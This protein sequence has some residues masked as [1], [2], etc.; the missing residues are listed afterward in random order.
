M[1]RNQK[2]NHCKNCTTMQNTKKGQ[3]KCCKWL[4]G[5]GKSTNDCKV[6]CDAQAMTGTKKQ[7]QAQ[8]KQQSSQKCS[9]G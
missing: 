1:K 3:E 5:K 9:L 8:D 6:Q 7:K 2:R 4:R